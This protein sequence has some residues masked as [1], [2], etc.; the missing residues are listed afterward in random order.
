MRLPRLVSACAKNAMIHK[1]LTQWLRTGVFA[2]VF[3][4][5]LAAGELVSLINATGA[6]QP[7]EAGA[8][9]FHLLGIGLLLHLLI[10]AWWGAAQTRSEIRS[11]T[12]QLYAITGLTQDQVV[13]GKVASMY[14]QLLFGVFCLAPYMFFAELL[15]GVDFFQ[16]IDALL[17]L[18]LLA[19][20]VF[21]IALMR[22]FKKPAPDIGA[23]IARMGCM[24]ALFFFGGPILIGI[25]V[26]IFNA[27]VPRYSGAFSVTKG[28]LGLHPETVVA[29]ILSIPI[30]F[31]VNVYLYAFCTSNLVD[32]VPALASTW[33]LRMNHHV[34][35]R[36]AEAE[37][38]AREAAA[39]EAAQ[40]EAAGGARG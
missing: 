15:G 6:E 1:D 25:L 3:L 28:L 24:I 26:A 37:R 31:I 21:I 39:G 33:I 11:R 38:E 13:W 7:S 40:P 17:G 16:V 29:V 5:L 12:F 14:V 23:M 36:V 8:S 10:V 22:G 18:L 35:Q 32:S 20:P 27:P 34:A 4:G 2:C 9:I 19:L 30:Y